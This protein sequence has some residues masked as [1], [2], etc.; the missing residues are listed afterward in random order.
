MNVTGFLFKKLTF[1]LQIDKRQF[2]FPIG[3]LQ[4]QLK[5]LNFLMIK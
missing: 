1:K 4:I 2:S 5:P 3:N